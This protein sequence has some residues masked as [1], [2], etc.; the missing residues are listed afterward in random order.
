MLLKQLH[1]TR[2]ESEFTATETKGKRVFKD[3][4]SSW[5]ALE[6]NLINVIRPALFANWCSAKSVSYSATET[7]KLGCFLDI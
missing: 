5:M 2:P 4:V 7:V 3:L 6:R 1:K